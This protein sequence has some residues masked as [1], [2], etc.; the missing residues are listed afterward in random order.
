MKT[1]NDRPALARPAPRSRAE[2]AA[3]ETARARQERIELAADAAWR[4]LAPVTRGAEESLAVLHLLLHALLDTAHM[5]M[6]RADFS[7]LHESWKSLLRSEPEGRYA[8][9]AGLRRL[10]RYPPGPRSRSPLGVDHS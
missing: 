7:E 2:F 10:D 3:E 8:L 6:T 5:K 1:P 4:A 9:G